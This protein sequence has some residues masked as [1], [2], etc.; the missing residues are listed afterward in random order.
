MMINGGENNSSS[1]VEA[2]TRNGTN[3]S[4]TISNQQDALEEMI[5]KEAAEELKLAWDAYLRM[6]KLSTSGFQEE[7]NDKDN[8]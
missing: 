8:R 5:R 6:A 2:S 1:S 3:P 7:A 4:T